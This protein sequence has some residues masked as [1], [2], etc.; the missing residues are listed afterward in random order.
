MEVINM[1]HAKPSG[2]Y[3]LG[4][5]E[6]ND[7]IMEIYNYFT[8]LGWSLEAISGMIGNMVAE[9]G[10]NPWRWQSDRVNYSGGYGLVQYTPASGYI[11]NYGAGVTG[12]APNLSTS[13][14]LGGNVSDAYAQMY[15][16]ANNSSGKFLNR[17][18]LCNYLDFSDCYP[19]S[20]Y[21]VNRDLWKCST[22]WLWNFEY[23]ADHS[24][25]VADYRY[26]LALQVYNYLSGETPEPPTPPPT[27]PPPTP[28]DPEFN[29]WFIIGGP[30]RETIRRIL[31]Q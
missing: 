4:S 29:I 19:L 28:P 23:P 12:F 11:N 26:F 22:A 16:I 17:N 20:A 31:G 13:E 7:N 9:S 6:A 18:Y 15:T 5:S 24:K 30:A 10:L 14:V 3:T 21:K 8:A 2:A 27:P 1:W 25:S